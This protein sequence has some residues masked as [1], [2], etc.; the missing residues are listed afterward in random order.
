MDISGGWLPL[1]GVDATVQKVEPTK[2]AEGLPEPLCPLKTLELK[3]LP[4]PSS[5]T[6][7]QS[8]SHEAAH[9]PGG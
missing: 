6:G 3:M 9:Y 4:K 2:L 5:S 1:Q 8:L 7:A